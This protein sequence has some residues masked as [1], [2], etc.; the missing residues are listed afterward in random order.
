MRSSWKKP[1]TWPRKDANRNQS[2]LE[3]VCQFAFY[4]SVKVLASIAGS[5]AEKRNGQ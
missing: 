2:T 4:D 5:A 3:T 1:I